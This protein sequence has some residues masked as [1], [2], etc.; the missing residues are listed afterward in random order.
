MTLMITPRENK[1]SSGRDAARSALSEQDETQPGDHRVSDV[2]VDAPDDEPL[3]RVPRGD[4]PLA[5][6]H[7]QPDR[8]HGQEETRGEA[9]APEERQDDFGRREWTARA[10][11]CPSRSATGSLR[12]W[13][14]SP[15]RGAG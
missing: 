13:R 4:G 3:R 2:S 1:P 14:A 12:G 7:E 9:N 8:G 10:R 6:R 15:C 5:G 11:A